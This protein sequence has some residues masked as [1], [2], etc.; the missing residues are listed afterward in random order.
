[1]PIRHLQTSAP[2]EAGAHWLEQ[3]SFPVRQVA[4]AAPQFVVPP[5]PPPDVPPEQT[6]SLL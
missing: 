1:L 6:L 2:D 4:P 5:P 3:Q